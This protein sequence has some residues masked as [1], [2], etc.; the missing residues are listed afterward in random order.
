MALHLEPCDAIRDNWQNG[1]W[2]ANGK[3]E[4]DAEMGLH[5]LNDESTI[6]HVREALDLRDGKWRQSARIGW[7]KGIANDKCDVR[8]QSG[9]PVRQS[10]LQ[11]VREGNVRGS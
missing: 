8:G 10:Q 3:R 7:Q 1:D 11:L 2:P 9:M 5:I 4:A 6:F